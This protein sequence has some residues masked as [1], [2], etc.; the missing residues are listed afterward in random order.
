MICPPPG[1]DGSWMA[2][3][4]R[5]GGTAAVLPIGCGMPFKFNGSRRH[6]IPRA[7]CHVRNWPTYDAGLE[8]RDDLTLRMD[9]TASDG[10][11]KEACRRSA[12]RDAVPRYGG[13]RRADRESIRIWRSEMVLVLVLV[14]RMVLH[15]AL[16]QAEA[17]AGS[18]LRLLRLDLRV[19]DHTTLSRRSRDFA[20]R[21]PRVTAHGAR[22]LIVDS[23]GL[24]L[25]GQGQWYAERHGR[26][27]RSRRKLHL[28]V[29]AET[30]RLLGLRWFVRIVASPLAILPARFNVLGKIIQDSL[31]PLTL[32]FDRILFF[33]IER[34]THRYTI[35][36][37]H[38]LDRA[39][40]VSK[41]VLNQLMGHDVGIRSGE[42]KADATVFGLHA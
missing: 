39:S 16:R 20:R 11:H 4:Q 41:G 42:V 1:G 37:R 14:L 28:V 27:R 35:S 10:W 33:S 34:D 17:V 23:T 18:V 15:L 29:D 30:G 36:S 12:L 6:H 26:S 24:K 25:F 19:P 9:E 5:G 38:E 31:P 32:L 21:R 8:P 22:H 3:V 13:T 2:L 40:T 7:R